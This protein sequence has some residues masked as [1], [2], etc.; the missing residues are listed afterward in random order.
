[1]KKFIIFLYLLFLS[2]NLYAG[3]V[4]KV[5]A[6]NSNY[7]KSE[8]QKS[9]DNYREAQIDQPD[10]PAINFNMGDSLY[11]MGQFDQA[12]TEYSKSAVFKDKKLQS[13]VYYNLGNNAFKREKYDEALNNYKKA[14]ELYPGNEDAKYNFEYVKRQKLNPKQKNKKNDK[15]KDNKDNKDKNKNDDKNKEDKNKMSKEDAKRILQYFDQSDKDSAKK[16]KMKMPQL[17]KV[18]EDW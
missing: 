12:G 9:L 2:Y 4:S 16:R 6:G 14:L 5:N 15:N 7:K 10:N 1:M 3:V 18:E 11:K 8:F 17:P 13:M